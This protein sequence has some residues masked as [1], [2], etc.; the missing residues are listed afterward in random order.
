MDI[1]DFRN[2]VIERYQSYV[3]SFVYIRDPDI[4]QYVDRHI[5]DGTF[6]PDPL[7]QLNPNFEPGGSVT[8]LVAQGTLHPGCADIFALDKA[9]GACRSTCTATSKKPPP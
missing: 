1:F 9:R 3:S 6:W 8:N 7:V 2:Q 5:N 4:H